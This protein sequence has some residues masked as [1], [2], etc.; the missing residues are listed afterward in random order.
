MTDLHPRHPA[1][2][3]TTSTAPD[4][5]EN[6]AGPVGQVDL[7]IEGMTCAACVARVEKRLGRLDGVTA[8]VNLATESAR[9]TL[10]HQRPAD[11]LVA[12]VVKAGY[13]ARV[14]AVRD[15]TAPPPAPGEPADTGSA[16]D[17]HDTS[18]PTRQRLADLR[19][20]L[21]VA[22]TRGLPVMVLSMVPAWQFT[23]W[24]WIVAALT[25]PIA[26][27]CAWPFHRSAFA[28][29]RHGAFTMDT[30]VSLGVIASTTWSLWALFLGG[31]GQL[32]M[33]MDMS[34]LP[35]LDGGLIGGTPTTGHGNGHDQDIPHLYFET[36]A[37]IVT[38]L[39][40][41][42]YAEARSRHR[43]GDA[44][45]SLLALGAKEATRVDTDPDGTR[46]HRQIPATALRLDDLI[47]VRPG[48]TVAT[49]GT[50][51][52]GHSAVDCS[53]LTGEPVPVDVAPGDEVA[54]GTV[55]STGA[56]VVRATRVGE[57]T[58]LARIARMVAEAQA[59]KAPVQ[60]LADRVS[61]VFVPV[62]L[63]I[64][65]AT[66]LTWV[67]TGRPLQAAFTAAVAV[68]VVACPCALG[69]ATPTA[70]LVGS[71]RAAQLG[72]VIKG[73]EILESTRRIDT[74]L[75]DKTGTLTTGRMSLASVHPL[76]GQDGDAAL[77]VAAA[78][79]QAS[80]HPIAAAV[81]DAARERGLALPEAAAVRA[82]T[83]L[84]VSAEV[85]VDGQARQVLVGRP[86]W[87]AD[88]GMAVD[89]VEEV[90][91]ALPGGATAVAVGWDGRARAVLAVSDTVKDEAADAVAQL[92]ALGV[93][94]YLLTGDRAE[95]AVQIAAEVGIAPDRVVAGVLPE[96]KTDEVRRLQGQGRVVAMV[97]D[98]VNDAAALTQADLG[99]AIGTGTDV[100]IEAGDLV[101]VSGDPRAAAAAVRVSRAT[102]RVV[103]QNLGWAFGY[104][105]IALPLA[106]A[107]LLNP[108]IA[109]AFMASSSV[110][111][112]GNSLRLRR[113][114]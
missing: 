68:L 112:V 49:D 27:W 94:P 26:T 4:A 18:A 16:P 30:L 41:G 24:Q 108:G 98:G 103:K 95:A 1:A 13:G 39:L 5:P 71:G 17:V 22:A 55:N 42:R 63:A 12:T 78:A 73:P 14:L 76:D 89:G 77:A 102:L 8:V 86:A 96:G 52:E 93:E 28:A 53:M 106:A 80:E 21:L 31:A 66:F 74:V 58:T 90:V 37:M 23:G 72:I 51:V 3:A 9:I 88:R 36:A 34:L 60:R 62:V 65:A 81:V 29:A 113:A 104:N 83:G 111:V 54:G 91:A 70:L 2:A 6:P 87:L 40:A 59:G 75:L 114:H 25:I 64:S 99:L 84:G 101:L 33:R 32:G 57:H 61:A 110:I 20:R 43:A 35:A 92:R 82:S 48:E 38:F 47:L 15:L 7:A 11:E 56:L 97:G 19:R 45:R 85:T 67:M 46:H 79:E 69:L 44:L 109:A 50:V 105:V 10:H 100:A 107:G